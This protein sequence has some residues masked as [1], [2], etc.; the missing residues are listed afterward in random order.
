MTCNRGFPFRSESNPRYR[1][2]HSGIRVESRY[3][4]RFQTRTTPAPLGRYIRALPTSSKAASGVWLPHYGFGA[5]QVCSTAARHHCAAFSGQSLPRRLVPCFY[6]PQAVPSS[7]GRPPAIV[8]APPS[9]SSM[10][11]TLRR[12]LQVL[13]LW[14]GCSPTATPCLFHGPSQYSGYAWRSS[15]STGVARW[16]PGGGKAFTFLDEG[17]VFTATLHYVKAVTFWN[18]RF[19]QYVWFGCCS[20]LGVLFCGLLLFSFLHRFH[21]SL[22]SLSVSVPPVTT[23]EDSVPDFL[24]IRSMKGRR[25]TW[26]ISNPRQLG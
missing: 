25:P 18:R 11:F 20:L 5:V 15:T 12:V 2:P 17:K 4:I 8:L 3:V 21:L 6:F 26:A 1:L 7:R 10:S 9:S 19:I 23:G 13:W 16:I 24:S 22:C 14:A